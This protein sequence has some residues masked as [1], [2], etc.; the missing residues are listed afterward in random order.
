MSKVIYEQS[1]WNKDHTKV[2]KKETRWDNGAR[3][4]EEHAT[5]SEG[6]EGYGDKDEISLFV[7]E[8]PDEEIVEYGVSWRDLCG[9][10][11]VSLHTSSEKSARKLFKA[12][13]G[14]TGYSTT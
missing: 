9:Y 10:F 8:N 11:S 5:T 13:Q 2:I 12:L 14:V 1:T 6:Y 4:L 7:Y 3:E